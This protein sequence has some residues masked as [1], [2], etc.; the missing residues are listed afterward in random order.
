MMNA[1]AAAA[2]AG[3]T[4]AT[5]R[6]W[7]RWKV[8]AAAKSAGAWSIDEASLDHRIA[9]GARRTAP[10]PVAYTVET[11][12]AIG[13]SRWTKGDKDRVYINDWSAFA[14]LDVARYGTG[15]ISS[16]AYQGSGISNSQAS[17]I[18]G[19]IDKVWYDTAD[20]K[21]HA[22]YGY[23]D[24]RMSREQVWADVV[25]GIRTAIAAL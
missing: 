22:R 11:M 23:T 1:T 9:L 2:K 5:V 8:V 17:K 20:G 14:G 25:T 6:A 10:K 21:L 16:A 7:C 12:T 4:V 19:C 18:F 24:P 13:G 3:V 15:N